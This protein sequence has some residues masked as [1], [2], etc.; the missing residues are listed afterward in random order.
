M[1]TGVL[2]T[3][4]AAALLHAGWNAL[5]KGRSG[6]DPLVGTMMPAI[7]CGIVAL[8]VLALAGLPSQESAIYVI[9]SGA[10]HVI[11]FLLVGLSYR[12]ADYSAVYPL[13]RGSAPLITT[14][15]SAAFL[16][17]PMTATLLCGVLL[18]SVGVLGLGANA[19]RKGGLNAR[20][21]YVALLNIGVIVG[22]TLLDGIGVRLSGNPAGYVAAMLALTAVMLLP[23]AIWLRLGTLAADVRAHWRFGLLGGTMAMI[24]YGIALWAMTKAPI[25]AVAAL[26]ETSVLFG[27]AIAAIVLKEHFGLERWIAAAAICGGLGLLRLA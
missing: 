13:M 24:S 21:L 3:V 5:A 17:E 10:V 6:S 22:Y 15:L 16:A 1:P 25:G 23:V 8:P 14:L 4:L 19:L 27:T 12:Y 2:V 26:R 7:A 9:V 20:G 18:L 11:Y